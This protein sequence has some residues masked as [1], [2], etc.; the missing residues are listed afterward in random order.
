M[1]LVIDEGHY[2]WP[3]SERVRSAPEYV[4]WIN[5]A[6]VNQG[7]PVAILATEQFARLK[8][9]TERLTGWTSSQFIHRVFRYKK[10]PD[11]PTEQDV[12]AV[13]CKLISYIWNEATGKWESGDNECSAKAIAGLVKY[14]MLEESIPLACVASCIENARMIA[15]DDGRIAVSSADLSAAFLQGQLPSDLALKRAFQPKGP[16]Q[17]GRKL[18]PS[19]SRAYVEAP[20]ADA[21][22]E[23]PQR[24]IRP[25]AP[26]TV[27]A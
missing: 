11:R 22:T 10:L 18:S 4:D 17:R 12:K 19:A 16:D 8:S 23:L 24:S 15:I 13:A 2:L 7:V 3:R 6:L 27:T 9:R 5:T 14:A 26:L 1:M 25:T 21:S 20:G